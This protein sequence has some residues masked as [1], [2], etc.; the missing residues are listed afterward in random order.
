MDY[1]LG[2]FLLL[3]NIRDCVGIGWVV[4]AGF[5]LRFCYV[6]KEYGKKIWPLV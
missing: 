5:I 2:C 4:F 1:S 6:F 3:G